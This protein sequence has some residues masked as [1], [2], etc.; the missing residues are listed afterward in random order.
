MRPTDEQ[1]EELKTKHG[2][3]LYDLE[4]D[5][6]EVTVV[7]TRPLKAAWDGFVDKLGRD[8]ESRSKAMTSLAKACTVFPPQPE[9]VSIIEEYPGVANTIARAIQETVGLD[10]KKSPGVS[11]R[12]AGPG[13]GQ[14]RLGLRG[15]VPAGP[16]RERRERARRERRSRRHRR[17]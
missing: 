5:E 16:S 8:E 13:Q 11:E 10:T 1:I 6:P 17:R 14:R 3:K 2:N 15:K 12:E 4:L 7:F 9:L